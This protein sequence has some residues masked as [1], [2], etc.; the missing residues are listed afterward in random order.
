M[1]EF[2]A[3]LNCSCAKG[4]PVSFRRTSTGKVRIMPV[5]PNCGQAYDAGRST[6]G[7]ETFKAEKRLLY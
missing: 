7:A 4:F 3:C 5:C 2:R 1:E 6:S